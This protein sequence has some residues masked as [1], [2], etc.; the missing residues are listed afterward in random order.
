MNYR[1]ELAIDRNG[2]GYIVALDGEDDEH[3][4]RLYRYKFVIDVSIYTFKSFTVK[5]QAVP[6]RQRLDAKSGQYYTSNNPPAPTEIITIP[7]HDRPEEVRHIQHDNYIQRLYTTRRITDNTMIAAFKG[8]DIFASVGDIDGDGVLDQRPIGNVHHPELVKRL[9]PIYAQRQPPEDWA[10][11]I[12]EAFCSLLYN[13]HYVDRIRQAQI[14][15]I[16]PSNTWSSVTLFNNNGNSSIPRRYAN[17]LYEGLREVT[18]SPRSVEGTCVPEVLYEAFI[19]NGCVTHHKRAVEKF[20]E[21]HL[22]EGVTLQVFSDFINSLGDVTL[23]VYDPLNRLVH[24]H[25]SK[26]LTKR[27]L[28]CRIEDN[29]LMLLADES[30]VRHAAQKKVLGSILTQLP[31]V[32]FNFS[33]IDWSKAIYTQDPKA[34]M[35]LGE[36]T[37]YVYEEG[38]TS[39]EDS[40]GFEMSRL[41]VHAMQTTGTKIANIA[42]DKNGPKS[43]QVPGCHNQVLRT[44]DYSDREELMELVST[45]FNALEYP[46]SLMHKGA[47]KWAN[48]SYAKIATLIFQSLGF[49]DYKLKSRLREEHYEALTSIWSVHPMQDCLCDNPLEWTDRVRTFDCVRN[50][51]AILYNQ[52]YHWNIFTEYATVVD[53]H[54]ESIDDMRPGEY[55]VKQQ[56]HLA[57]PSMKVPPGMY[58]SDFLMECMNKGFLNPSFITK[59]MRADT[60][61]PGEYFQT[62]IDHVYDLPD[63]HGVRHKRLVNFF[64]GNLCK[65]RKSTDYTFV[66]DNPQVRDAAVNEY[67]DD[68]SIQCINYWEDTEP[69]IYV[70]HVH[71][72]Q[73]ETFTGYPI[74]RQ[75]FCRSWLYLSDMWESVSKPETLLISFKCDAI[76]VFDPHP[77]IHLFRGLKK[78]LADLGKTHEE[79]PHIHY[80]KA[81]IRPLISPHRQAF[82]QLCAERAILDKR[83]QWRYA[84]TRETMPALEL[85]S[86]ALITGPGG[87]GKSYII[88]DLMRRFPNHWALCYQ[89]VACANLRNATGSANV[90]TFDSYFQNRDIGGDILSTDDRQQRLNELA[91]YDVLFVDEFG[92]TPP[93][94]FTFLYH[95]WILSGRRLRIFIAGDINQTVYI[96]NSKNDFRYNYKETD[97]MKLICNETIITLD[98]IEGVTRCDPPLVKV[99]KHVLEEKKLPIELIQQ[100]CD[101]EQE[102]E[103]YSICQTRTRGAF[104]VEK[105]HKRLNPSGIIGAGQEV[106]C[107]I[108]AK[109]V[110]TPLHDRAVNDDKHVYNGN[111]Y[112]VVDVSANKV[113]LRGTLSL[114]GKEIE[115]SRAFFSKKQPGKQLPSFEE[116]RA[117]TVYRVQGQTLDEVNRPLIHIRNTHSMTLEEVYTALSRAKKL[118]QIRIDWTMKTFKRTAFDEYSIHIDIR[119]DKDLIQGKIYEILDYSLSPGKAVIYVGMTT[120]TIEEEYQDIVDAAATNT[121]STRPITTYIQEAMNKGA[122]NFIRVK[123]LEEYPC[124]KVSQLHEREVYHIQ[125]RQK[126]GHPIKNSQ[127]LQEEKIPDPANRWTPIINPTQRMQT[128]EMFNQFARELAVANNSWRLTKQYGGSKL[129]AIDKKKRKVSCNL[130]IP[131]DLA[132]RNIKRKLMQESQIYNRPPPVF[133]AVQHHKDVVD[134]LNAL[135]AN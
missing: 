89:N 88:A 17:E 8:Y 83:P 79:E 5:P 47:Y 97:L 106:I 30:L 74:S 127:N 128:M 37:V 29:H 115:V 66:T 96:P 28:V 57:H 130:D 10:E 35:M 76:T 1:R 132:F 109:D 68:I 6:P 42:W 94:Y 103:A 63:P 95:A 93:H 116:N 133:E 125:R 20:I 34:D 48:Q 65:F 52:E 80:G 14:Y 39:C 105:I 121:G 19:Q 70:C 84:Y 131:L 112:R 73:P 119:N 18:D 49:S 7:P 75:V 85:I 123:L 24:L 56:F 54:I 27:C 99:L 120:R 16:D 60:H 55:F 86:G 31:G 53:V 108:N 40:G 81:R 59:Y 98:Y 78:T 50:Y 46:K 36:D 71:E 26:Q 135:S 82:L 101:D 15:Q 100:P 118:S 44:K 33:D 77:D 13:K 129:T 122:M 72:E 62:F 114:H 87:A 67:K 91:E 61:L 104:S 90:S 3:P 134:L 4:R 12:A 124:H 102:H 9:Y 22:K 110:A 113:R 2:R 23:L 111:T 11:R 69:P 126:Q 51:A 64:L 92:Q 25:L 58:P 41:M 43:F 38:A 107:T 117:Q 32:G 21:E 45:R